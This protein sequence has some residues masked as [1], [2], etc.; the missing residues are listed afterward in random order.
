MKEKGV[1]IQYVDNKY[2]VV[3]SL[4]KTKICDNLQSCLDVVCDFFEPTLTEEVSATD[5]VKS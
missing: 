3:N 4:Q 5:D 2:V 1:I